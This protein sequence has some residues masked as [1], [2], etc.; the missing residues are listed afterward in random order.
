MGVKASASITLSSVVDIEDAQRYYKLQESTLPKP[1]KPTINPPEGWS[2]TEPGY[3]N[4]S[5]SCLYF[6]DLTVFS[7]GSFSYSEVS[8]SSSYEA[9][10]EAYKKAGYDTS[11]EAVPWQGQEP[12]RNEPAT[13]EQAGAQRSEEPGAEENIPGEGAKEKAEA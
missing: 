10:K 1:E 11:G 3:T 6:C 2:K 7:D 8:L 13:D 12:K 9:A 4:G 5:T